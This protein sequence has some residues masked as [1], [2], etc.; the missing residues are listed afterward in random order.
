MA[1]GEKEIIW[2][3]WREWCWKGWG[4]FK[5]PWRCS[6]GEYLERYRYDFAIVR[7]H[8]AFFHT[9]YEGCCEFSAAKFKWTSGFCIFC[10]GNGP[11][12][13]NVTKYFKNPLIAVGDCD[14]GRSP[15]G[16]VVVYKGGPAMFSARSTGSMPKQNT[17]QT[18]L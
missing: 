11:D 5:V 14:I 3:T 7:P 8:I 12:Y 17:K 1:C 4:P 18:E 2:V 13:Y 10:V 9:K 6:K 16:G 15:V